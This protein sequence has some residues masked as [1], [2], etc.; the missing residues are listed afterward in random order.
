MS[1]KRR[2]CLPL[3]VRRWTK[4][5]EPSWQWALRRSVAPRWAVSACLQRVPPAA[6]RP[7]GMACCVP[8]FQPVKGW[9]AA[10]SKC[11]IRKQTPITFLVFPH[12]PA[13]E[14]ADMDR[15]ALKEFGLEDFSSMLRWAMREEAE[16][17]AAVR[18][19]KRYTGWGRKKASIR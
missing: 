1:Q 14:D 7:A 12:P 6:T 17:A 3:L 11:L 19:R 2:T 13:A 4:G 16:E 18:R 5:G 9:T 15:S 10:R 8:M